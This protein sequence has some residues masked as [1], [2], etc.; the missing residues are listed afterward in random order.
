[1]GLLA[2]L[3]VALSVSAQA[4]TILSGAGAGALG[5]GG[6]GEAPAAGLGNL[7]YDMV[8]G[9]SAGPTPSPQRVSYTGSGLPPGAGDA[10]WTPPPTPGN[11]EREWRTGWAGQARRPPITLAPAKPLLGPEDE[12]RLVDLDELK[13]VGWRELT[14]LQIRLQGDGY[15]DRQ[16]DTYGQLNPFLN[17]DTL[18]NTRDA[19]KRYEVDQ[20]PAIALR[21]E[22]SVVCMK[23]WSAL[24]LETPEGMS[25]IMMSSILTDAE[26]AAE[27]AAIERGVGYARQA[28]DKEYAERQLAPFK[29]GDVQY[30]DWDLNF[31]SL[32]R[33]YYLQWQGKVGGETLTKWAAK[34]ADMGLSIFEKLQEAGE[35][36]GG[37][38]PLTLIGTAG[39]FAAELFF[40]AKS[41]GGPQPGLEDFHESTVKPKFDKAIL[42]AMVMYTLVYASPL[43]YVVARS[44][45][46]AKPLN[47]HNFAK[48]QMFLLIDDIKR[49]SGAG[50]ISEGAKAVAV[51]YM[52]EIIY[53]MV[54]HDARRD[55]LAKF[56]REAAKAAASANVTEVAASLS[57]G[58]SGRR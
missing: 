34:A 31:W 27:M 48:G 1:V 38:L 58:K 23:A 52:R 7:A 14:R 51:S 39:L 54:D 26:A 44:G 55:Y 25:V 12:R 32:G 42:A 41:D 8:A 36:T 3:P 15:L 29:H 40:G 43:R 56:Q 16:V 22:R 20:F 45:D 49:A 10:A 33:D 17:L 2:G 30:I 11:L 18:K 50:R 4:K 28:L 6:A 57:A 24:G 46:N 35:I 21:D 47:F 37:Y 5:A 53:Y 13:K 19:V 9:A